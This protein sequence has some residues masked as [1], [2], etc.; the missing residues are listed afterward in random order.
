[1]KSIQ[2]NVIVIGGGA[3]GMMAAGRAANLG[4]RVLLLEKNAKL[5]AK[6]SITGGGRC[7]ITNAEDD[8]RLFLSKYGTADNFLHSAFSQFGMRNTFSFFES[9][10]LPLKVEAHKRVFP[11][12]ERAT[13]VVTTLVRYLA[14]GKV[15]VRT[16]VAVRKIV[17]KNGRIESVQTSAGDFS[18]HSY[19]L[20]TGG[21]SHPE[22]GSTGDGFAWLLDLGHTITTPTPTIVPLKVKEEWVRSLAGV[23]LESVK[24]TFFVDEVKKFAR[25]GPLLFTHFG[26]SGPT[27]L[28]SAGKVSGLL[29]EGIV[30]AHLDLFPGA[31]QGALDKKITEVFDANKNKALKNVLKEI[32][33]PGM[34]DALLA[35]MV[36]IDPETKVHSVTKENRKEIAKHL[37]CVL[38]TITELMGFDRAVVADGG[39]PLTEIDMRTM[40]SKMYE[41]LFVTG[42]LLHICR[43]SGGY[44]LQLCWT[45]GF[46][47]GTHAV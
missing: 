16:G 32:V 34:S 5:G 38:L 12:T 8:Q 35:L 46:V 30:T 4:K 40:R 44:S 17:A 39:L 26:I 22:T 11:T 28:N 43:P 27:V 13:D 3:S 10:G 42:D 29:S 1:M 7:N 19:V 9:K 45:T 21:M 18:A 15:E 6:L 31:D 41:N 23:S 24:I 47:A 2:Y 20:A 36:D 25:M 37:K 14:E 33:P